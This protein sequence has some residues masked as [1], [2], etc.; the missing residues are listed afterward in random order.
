MAPDPAAPTAAQAAPKESVQVI[1]LRLITSAWLAS[2]VFMLLHV[3]FYIVPLFQLISSD[4]SLSSSAF[5]YRALIF[6]AGVYVLSFISQPIPGAGLSFTERAKVCLNDWNVQY[7]F[8]CL[9]MWNVAVP[10]TTFL[11]P[12][13]IYAAYFVSSHIAYGIPSTAPYVSKMTAYQPQALQM[14]CSMEFFTIFS[15]IVTAILSDYSAL[16]AILVYYMFLNRRYA[17]D[18]LFRGVMDQLGMKLDETASTYLPLVAQGWVRRAK[19]FFYA[20]AMEMNRLN[21]PQPQPPPART[22]E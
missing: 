4:P 21:Q 1:M 9:A 2:N 7:T 15:L 16:F 5:Y 17:R 12:I 14:A 10:I 19:H 22:S 6:A 18:A 3:V 13:S 11:V 20:T 8:V